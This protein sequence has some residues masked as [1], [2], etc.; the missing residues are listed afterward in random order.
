MKHQLMIE[1]SGQPW[2]D[3]YITE[4]YN[5]DSGYLDYMDQVFAKRLAEE[6]AIRK[7]QGLD[8]WREAD[9]TEVDFTPASWW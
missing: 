9:G 8:V 6:N 7:S 4:M 3:T 2:D 1:W 5:T